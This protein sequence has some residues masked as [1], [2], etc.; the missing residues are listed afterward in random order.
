V[1]IKRTFYGSPDAAAVQVLVENFKRH[2]DKVSK[3][4]L[5]A[6]IVKVSL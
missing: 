1:L 4:P 6:R 3:F 5:L 2:N